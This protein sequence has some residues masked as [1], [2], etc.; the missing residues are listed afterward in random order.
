MDISKKQ[1]S[2]SK[3]NCLQS[4]VL[5]EYIFT[6]Q[7]ELTLT[8]QRLAHP[9]SEEIEKKV[10]GGKERDGFRKGDIDIHVEL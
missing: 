2:L 9:I 5:G 4:P 6:H 8:I 1:H 7:S 10:E 3:K